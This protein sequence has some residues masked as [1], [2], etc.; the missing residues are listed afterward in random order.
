M[1]Q[2]TIRIQIV[3][4][5]LLLCPAC[6]CAQSPEGI[7]I[8]MD[9][10]PLGV[11]HLNGS[12][13]GQ[14]ADDVLIDAEGRVGIGTV[15]PTARLTIDTQDAAGVYPIRL[16]DGSEGKSG[17]ILVAADADGHASWQTITPPAPDVVYSI[18]TLSSPAL[19]F[20]VGSATKI[21]KSEFS[22]TADGFYSVD[23]RWWAQYDNSSTSTLQKTVTRFQLVRSRSGQN[24]VI[25]EI[26]HHDVARSIWTTFFVLYA[27]AKAGDKLSLYVWPEV[28]PSG[29]TQHQIGT[30]TLDWCQSK[31]MYKKLG[32]GNA[33]LFN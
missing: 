11:F 7:G 14:A 23:V 33:N 29:S 20:P 9:T 24:N 32:I 31:V 27:T 15:N 26:R 28:Y 5:L 12:A 22:V 8:N 10:A 1:I 19:S 13:A 16:R 6:I 2:K 21:A 25:D 17:D 3:S 18:T 30:L 4:G